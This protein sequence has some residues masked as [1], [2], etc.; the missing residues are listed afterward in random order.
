MMCVDVL[1][2]L[3][4]T[5]SHTIIR[6]PAVG[7]LDGM[8]LPSRFK[9][10][11][12]FLAASNPGLVMSRFDT[13]GPWLAATSPRCL[14]GMLMTVDRTIVRGLGQVTWGNNIKRCVRSC[15]LYLPGSRP[16]SSPRLH[17]RSRPRARSCSRLRFRSRFRPCSHSSFLP[18]SRQR[19]CAYARTCTRA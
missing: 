14:F 1:L 9:H 8:L 6:I 12:E 7:L 2:D 5:S 3:T 4:N 16:R 11:I 19:S 10:N 17:P 13:A 15:R 18:C